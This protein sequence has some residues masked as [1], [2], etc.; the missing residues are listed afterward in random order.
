MTDTVE[1]FSRG[2]GV[3]SLWTGVLTAPIAFL[4]NLEASYIIVPRVCATGAEIPLH[5]VSLTM[6]LFAAFGGFIAWRNWQRTGRGDET[7]SRSE[8]PVMTRSRF[9]S[10]WGTLMSLLFI[11]V[12]LA[13]WIPSFFLDPCQR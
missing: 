9:M 3:R 11:L 13:Q 10:I 5:L 4:V 12:I 7:V 2:A 6:L 1:Y 8:E